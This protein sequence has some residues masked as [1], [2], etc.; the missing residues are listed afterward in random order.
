M[1]QR[2]SIPVGNPDPELGLTEEQVRH[3]IQAGWV[4]GS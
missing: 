4:S 3:R 2:E 1:E